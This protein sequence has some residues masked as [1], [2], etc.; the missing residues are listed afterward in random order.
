MRLQ[1]VI[2]Q[3]IRKVVGGVD[4]SSDVNAALAANVG[5]RSQTTRVSSHST[6]TAGPRSEREEESDD[7][8]EQGKERPG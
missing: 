1:K 6:A 7:G 2:Q 5:E 4:F 3:R 8:R